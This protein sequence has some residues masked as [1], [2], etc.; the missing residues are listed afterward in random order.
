[1]AVPQI[2]FV[3]LK[4]I[5]SPDKLTYSKLFIISRSVEWDLIRKAKID[6]GKTYKYSKG[7]YSLNLFGDKDKHLLSINLKPFTQEGVVETARA[8]QE[9]S[10]GVVCDKTVQALARGTINEL[11]NQGIKEIWKLLIWLF[12]VLFAIALIRAFVFR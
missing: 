5:I 2:I 4:I 11:T 7:F 6:A 12:F 3:S 10:P 8:I 1:M 9:R